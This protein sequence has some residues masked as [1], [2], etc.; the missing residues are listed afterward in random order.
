MGNK[1]KNNGTGHVLLNRKICCAVWATFSHA[2]ILDLELNKA[3]R[4]IT[5]CLKPIYVEELHLL[6]GIVPPNIRRDV[7]ARMERPKQME[8]ETHSLFSHIPARGRLKSMKDFLASVKHQ[9]AEEIKEAP[10][11]TSYKRWS[12]HH[13][14]KLLCKLCLNPRPQQ[15]GPI[16]H[17]LCKPAMW[18]RWMA[19][20]APHK[21]G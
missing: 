17:F 9:T 10:N 18:T 2:D 12:C 15:W 19:G 16:Y 6:T 4:A 5:E 21:K 11:H 20:A 1:Y 7:Y 13:E 8:Q 14:N 3:W